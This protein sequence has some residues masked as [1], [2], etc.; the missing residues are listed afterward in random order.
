MYAPFFLVVTSGWFISVQWIFGASATGST[1]YSAQ[2]SNA[3]AI[4]YHSLHRQ[5]GHSTEGKTHHYHV[6]SHL[7]W[8]LHNH[9]IP[10]SIRQ[11]VDTS[12]AAA[13]WCMLS[14]VDHIPSNL[15][16]RVHEMWQW[17]HILNSA[18]SRQERGVAFLRI[19]SQLL[20][21]GR[22]EVMRIWQVQ[23]LRL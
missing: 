8:S 20:K 18:L 19:K 4:P 10:G 11:W 5:Q 22:C 15:C 9:H 17:Q 12:L 3:A 16:P 13:C 6:S 7:Y 21:W 14:R 1:R 2:L 23:S